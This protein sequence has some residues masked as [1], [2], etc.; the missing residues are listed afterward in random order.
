M[1][2]N[3]DERRDRKPSI[4]QLINT[5]TE[6]DDTTPTISVFDESP[7]K[8]RRTTENSTNQA[9]SSKFANVASCDGVPST[10]Q[11]PSA[12]IIAAEENSNSNDAVTTTSKSHS[13]KS[14]SQNGPSSS[15]LQISKRNQKIQRGIQSLMDEP[16]CD[17][18]TRAL[19]GAINADMKQRLF[20]HQ[21]KLKKIQVIIRITTNLRLME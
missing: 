9:N 5:N 3:D 19:V 14:T 18:T 15:G 17:Q 10:V 13:F 11:G 2:T 8:R 16:L 6:I 20:T 1:V 12:T 7:A 4:G 21:E